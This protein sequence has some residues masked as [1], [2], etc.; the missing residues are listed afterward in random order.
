M[1]PS[2]SAP[3]PW[4]WRCDSWPGSGRCGRWSRTLPVEAD[5]VG[6]EIGGDDLGPGGAGA[7]R[8]IDRE[9][10]GEQL[11]QLVVVEGMATSLMGDADPLISDGDIAGVDLAGTEHS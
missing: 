10:A 9:V 3:C 2:G 7:E 1:P 6:G 4:S 8:D 11:G 5:V